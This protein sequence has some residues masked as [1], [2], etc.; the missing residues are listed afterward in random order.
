MTVVER[1]ASQRGVVRFEANRSI[2]GM[3]HLHYASAGDAA[4]D[5]PPDRLAR[6]LF[7][8]GGIDGVH[9]NSNIITVDL[10]KGS[11][12]EGIRELIES[13]FLHYR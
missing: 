9:I 6:L 3:G 10:T 12:A 8:R 1:Q 5:T 11:D 7:E 2:T 4:E 13:M